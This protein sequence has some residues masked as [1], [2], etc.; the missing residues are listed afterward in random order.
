MWWNMPVIPALAE[1]EA[2]GLRFRGHGGLPSENWSQKKGKLW[3]F[4]AKTSFDFY[5]N[6]L[7]LP[8]FCKDGSLPAISSTPIYLEHVT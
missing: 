5:L 1:A 8:T 4:M 3:F 2:G 7:A 6:C